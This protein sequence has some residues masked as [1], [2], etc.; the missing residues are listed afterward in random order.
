MVTVNCA[1]GR[2]CEEKRCNAAQ[3]VKSKGHIQQKGILPASTS[4]LQ[5]DDE[6]ARLQRNRSLASALNVDIDPISTLSERS[7]LHQISATNLPYSADTLDMYAQLSSSSTLATLR[8]YEITLQ[9]LATSTTQRSI[10]FQPT[11]PAL[12]AFIHS[13]AADWGF[14]SES[15]DPEPHRHV[16]VVKPQQWSSSV[17][18]AGLATTV[19]IGGM[20]VGD[21]AKF[22]EEERFR[23]REAQRI[24]A[25]EAKAL[26]EAKTASSIGDGGWTQVA[27][28]SKEQNP[29]PL[30]DI[31]NPHQ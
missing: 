9:S 11:R 20:T 21:C 25:A 23:T 14:V 5:C 2:L 19:G 6:C 3:A 8:E 12:R 18:G 15:F 27:Y 1:C 22:R 29:L 24:A 30:T 17:L 16:L 10:R 13:L 4:R 28:R 7:S 31:L 26:R